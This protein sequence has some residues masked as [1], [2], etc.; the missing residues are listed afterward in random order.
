MFEYDYRCQRA[1]IYVVIQRENPTLD[2][3]TKIGTAVQQLHE[4]V[5]I[6]KI[7]HELCATIHILHE[8][9]VAVHTFFYGQFA[10]NARNMSARC[11]FCTVVQPKARANTQL[12]HVP[13]PSNEFKMWHCSQILGFAI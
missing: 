9:S 10:R 6:Q 2:I 12:S 1:F 13:I 5:E 3:C 4:T 8:G 7:M 11:T